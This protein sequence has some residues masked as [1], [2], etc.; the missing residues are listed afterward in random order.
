MAG[1]EEPLNSVIVMAAASRRR[2]VRFVMTQAGK[3]PEHLA[4]PHIRNGPHF[5]G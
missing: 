4:H 5:Q 1:H 2:N 3:L